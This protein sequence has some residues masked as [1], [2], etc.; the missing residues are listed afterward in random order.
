MKLI[1]VWR[2]IA[3][4]PAPDAVRKKLLHRSHLDLIEAMATAES[5]AAQAASYTHH[6]EMLRHRIARLSSEAANG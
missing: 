4:P 2:A 6:A 1:D 3:H 5:L